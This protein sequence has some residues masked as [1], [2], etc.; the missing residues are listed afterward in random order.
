MQ[1]IRWGILG[2]ARIARK[3][4]RAILHSGNGVVTAVAARELER[5]RAF[6]SE[7][8]AACPFAASPRVFPDYA[9][10]LASPE[11]DAVYVPLPTALRPKWIQRAAASGKHVLCEKPCAVSAA[12]LQP[13]LAA[14]RQHRVQFMDGV[15]FMHHPRLARLRAVLDD[16]ELFGEVRRLHAN[17]NF[18]AGPEFMTGNIRVNSAL[19][20]L[21]CLGDLGWYCVRFA[22][23]TLNWQWP[24]R[25]T[26]RRL[27]GQGD[28]PTEFS[29]ELF[30]E[31]GVSASFYC[32]FIANQSQLA[33]IVGTKAVVE[34][35]DFV[36]PFTDREVGFDLRRNVSATVGGEWKIASEVTRITTGDHGADPA[37][38][39]EARMFRNFAAQV[40]SGV[41]SEHWFAV[42]AQTQAIVDALMTAAR[43]EAA[44]VV[45]PG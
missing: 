14:C 31:G 9:A 19:E 45:R 28:V 37:N 40:Q 34:I 20:P 7:C 12:A 17:F 26:A 4:W 15:M 21:G 30:F 24:V 43:T 13:L 25:V 2:A 32:S 27:G 22:L 8:Q 44:V 33:A 11:V 36:L 41:L 38:S 10:V 42:A 18:L 1:P 29:G 39:Q 5:A 35:A 6:V 23:W 16:R 3:N